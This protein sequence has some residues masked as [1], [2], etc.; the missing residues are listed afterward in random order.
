[1]K[2]MSA[3]SRRL[4]DW[5]SLPAKT[6]EQES[7]AELLTILVEKFEERL[8]SRLRVAARCSEVSNGGP[9]LRQR[10]LIQ[11]FGSR[12]VVWDVINGKRG[13]SKQHALKLAEYFSVPVSLFIG[14]SDDAGVSKPGP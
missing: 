12:S 3:S 4:S 13:I 5:D 11:T 14:P 10:D 6:P 7:L 8:R 1:M 9:E 2:K